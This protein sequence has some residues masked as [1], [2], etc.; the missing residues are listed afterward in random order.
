MKRR[1][2]GQLLLGSP[3]LLT[4]PMKSLNSSQQKKTRKP[5]RLKKGDVVGLIAPA[6]AASAEKFEKA[7]ANIKALGLQIKVGQYARL[8]TG[9]LA[10]TDDQRLSDLHGMYMDKNVQAIWAVRGGYGTTRILSKINY[11]LIQRNPK[12]LIGYSDITGL[13]NA[14]YAKTGVVGFHGPVGSSGFTDYNLTYLRK[15]L[16]EGPDKMELKIGDANN[17]E[18]DPA[19]RPRVITSGIMT[20]KLIGGNLTLLSAMAGTCQLPD[21]KNKIVFIEDIGE[22]PYRIDR[23]LTQLLNATNLAKASG[24]LLGVFYDCETKNT[25]SSFT[26]EAVLNERLGGLGVPVFYGF[27]IGHIDDMVTI[28][29]GIRAQ[30]NTGTQV[31][32]YLE[33]PFTS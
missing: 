23:M 6:S 28:P 2:F 17:H 15:V 12:I 24:I 22:K 3:L 27:P 11:S 4:K 21:F 31:L 5:A 20:G 29:V 14:I 10:G 26:L 33:S 9:F 32:T 19:F 18:K 30:F 13:T 25:D 16:F 1:K 8:K 7:I